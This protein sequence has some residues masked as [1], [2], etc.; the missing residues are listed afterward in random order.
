[1]SRSYLFDWCNRCHK[2]TPQEPVYYSN[3]YA[4]CQCKV[5]GKVNLEIDKR[6]TGFANEV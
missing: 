4:G 3:V 5:C 2:K 1:M 6:H